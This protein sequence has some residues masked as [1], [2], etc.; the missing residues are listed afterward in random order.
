MK[1]TVVVARLEALRRDLTA[2]LT[3]AEVDLRVPGSLLSEGDQPE[4]RTSQSSNV[5]ALHHLNMAVAEVDAAI[6]RAID[7]SYGI[8]TECREAI[9]QA[10]L[11]ANPVAIRC[12]ACQGKHERGRK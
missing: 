1:R 2:D 7:G 6:E 4:H 11:V 12:A 8:C 10:R 3:A 9:P 5:S